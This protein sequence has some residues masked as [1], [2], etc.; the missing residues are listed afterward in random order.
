MNNLL[1]RIKK[2]YEMTIHNWKNDCE[3][4][5]KLACLH[6]IDDVGGRV[7]FHKLSCWAHSKKDEWIL[8]YLQ[9]MLESLIQKYKE[10][11]DQGIPVENAPIWVCW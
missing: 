6:L 8:N 10:C 4:S 2:R 11:D 3:F 1:Y 7:G 9:G 5:K